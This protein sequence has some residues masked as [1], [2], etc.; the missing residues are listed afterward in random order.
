MRIAHIFGAPVID[1]QGKRAARISGRP[2]SGRSLARTWLT[3]WWTVGYVST[4]KSFGTESVPTSLII[5]MSLRRRST[6]MRFSAWVFS[7]ASMAATIAASSSGVA[8]RGAVPFI[9]CVSIQRS[10]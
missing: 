10:P 9:G 6:I 1:P 2:I 8:P 5:E 4:A 7:S 3:S